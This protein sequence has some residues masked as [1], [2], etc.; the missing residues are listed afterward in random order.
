M[1]EKTIKCQVCQQPV[2]ETN[3]YRSKIN[4]KFVVGHY[5]CLQKKMLEKGLS[6]NMINESTITK[7]GILFE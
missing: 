1:S 5:D 3:L 4:E 7:T 2:E 6:E